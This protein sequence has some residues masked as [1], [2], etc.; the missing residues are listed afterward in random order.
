MQNLPVRLYFLYCIIQL[1]HDKKRSS[2]NFIQVI[3]QITIY[4]KNLK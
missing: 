4:V 2:I 3:L 1:F